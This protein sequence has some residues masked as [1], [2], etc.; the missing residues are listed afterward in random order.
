VIAG[1]ARSFDVQ[2]AAVDVAVERRT[3]DAAIDQDIQLAGRLGITGTPSFVINGYRLVG[4]QP[5]ERFDRLIRLALAD[6]AVQ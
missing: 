1:H 2:P 5:K 6:Q 4:A 3:H